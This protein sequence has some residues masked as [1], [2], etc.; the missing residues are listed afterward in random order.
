MNKI[1][2]DLKFNEIVKGL[3]F[4]PTLLL[5]S[6]CGPCSSSVLDKIKDIFN[7]TVIYYNPNI[8][9]EEEYLKRKAEQVRLLKELNI[10]FLDC[11]YNEDEYLTYVLGLENEPEGGARCSKCFY[12]RMEKTAILALQNGYNYFGTTL[13][14]SP[15]K[16]EQIIN[17]IGESLQEKYNIPYLYADFKKHNGYLNSIILSKKY[18]LYRQDYCGC[19]YSKGN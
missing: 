4:K 10:S 19:R 1:N 6:C 14:V 17:K 3:N 9:P 5:H 8:F 16:N 7:V 2:Y 13:T 12:L 15:H 11:D 18:N